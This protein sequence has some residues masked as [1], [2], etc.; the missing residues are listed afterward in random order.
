MKKIAVFLLI[1]IAIVSTVSY[2]YLN[3]KAEYNISQK[4]N[5]KI[6]V[7]IE[8]EIQG[9]DLTTII[10]QVIDQNEK[11]E[12]EKDQEGNYIDNEKNSINIDIQF[13]DSDVIYNIEKIYNAGVDTFLSYYRNITFKCVDVQYHKTGHIKYIKFEQITQ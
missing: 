1:I 13:I 10:N 5:A 6:D 11:N 8:K 3:Y 7:Y 9:I 12:I 2:L 4:E